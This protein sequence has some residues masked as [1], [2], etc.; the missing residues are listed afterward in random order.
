MTQNLP[1]NR[2]TI[3]DPQLK[4]RTKELGDAIN[5]SLS[6]SK[7]ISEAVSRIKEDG[8]QILLVL[9]ATIGLSKQGEK[10]PDNTSLV[11][12][13]SKLSAAS[14]RWEGQYVR[15]WPTKPDGTPNP[16]AGKAG[17]VR[18]VLQLGTQMR[19][20]V[21]VDNDFIVVTLESL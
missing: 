8:Y 16:S 12:N 4:G 9:E 11:T 20:V 7:E 21:E 6:D 3:M 19:A 17:R 1:A 2:R 18:K 10:S 13:L 14:A 15:V 5:K